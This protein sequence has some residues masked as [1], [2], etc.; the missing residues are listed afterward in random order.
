MKNYIQ[1]IAYT[2]LAGIALTLAN[3]VFAAGND[4]V[5]QNPRIK[6]AGESLIAVTHNSYNYIDKVQTIVGSLG[7]WLGN[8]D[9]NTS[10][11]EFSFGAELV[12][13]YINST[14]IPKKKKD[15]LYSTMRGI[16]FR[17]FY[18]D[19]PSSKKA[20][21]TLEQRIE[22][23][24]AVILID[25]QDKLLENINREEVYTEIQNQIE[26]ITYAQEHN[27]PIFLLEFEGLGKTNGKL[28]DALSK[29]PYETIVKLENNGFINTT[30]DI[31]LQQK[32][33][34][35]LILMGAYASA[36]VLSTANGAI[37][38]GYKIATSKEVILDAEKLSEYN[39]SIGWYYSYGRLFLSTNGLIEYMKSGSSLPPKKKKKFHKR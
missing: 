33:I 39:E 30:L 7:D 37:E 17:L 34:K 13:D 31:M 11:Q 19:I 27:I 4:S 23:N 28:K 20:H 24:T 1:K 21:N 36:C 12:F 10:P 9:G 8:M 6:R 5:L 2:A 16:S 14:E 3:P 38:N 35:E 26:V 29:S 22:P 15:L 18:S 25:M 32:A